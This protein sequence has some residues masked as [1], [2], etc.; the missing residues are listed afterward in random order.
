MDQ[1]GT[2]LKVGAGA[3]PRPAPW[4]LAAL[5]A[6]ATPARGPATSGI[7]RSRLTPGSQWL[8]SC[9]WQGAES[10]GYSGVGRD[11]ALKR[12]DILSES[13][14]RPARSAQSAAGRL[15]A[16]SATEGSGLHLHMD[17]AAATARYSA[18]RQAGARLKARI[19]VL[20]F[21]GTKNSMARWAGLITF[22]SRD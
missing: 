9:C 15:K 2:I 13:L 22:G 1:L 21:G 19:D 6:Q 10:N 3:T 5:C 7:N 14:P 4:P 11:V 8:R 17:G 20:A 12:Q 18:A 16:I